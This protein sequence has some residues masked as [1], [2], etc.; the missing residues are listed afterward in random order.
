MAELSSRL[1]EG[2]SSVAR[3]GGLFAEMGGEPR[4]ITHRSKH[5]DAQLKHHRVLRTQLLQHLRRLVRQRVG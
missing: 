5:R 3:G 2:V 1:V 4:D